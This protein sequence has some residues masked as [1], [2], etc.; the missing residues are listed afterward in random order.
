MRIVIILVTFWLFLNLQSKAQS[1]LYVSKNNKFIANFHA[2]DEITFKIEGE[3]YYM[4]QMIIGFRG[5]NIQFHYFDLAI[6]DITHI[7]IS[8]SRKTVFDVLSRYTLQAGVLFLLID[9]FNQGVIRDEGFEPSS[10]SLII[11][12]SLLASSA[13]TKLLSK[14]K[15]KIDKRKVKLQTL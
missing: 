1:G 6:A 11:T 4:T 5:D 12:G 13:I 2:G 7:D 9:T 14:K 15:F 3:D 10:P 8:E